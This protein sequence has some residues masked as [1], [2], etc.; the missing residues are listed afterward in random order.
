MQKFKIVP[1]GTLKGNCLSFEYFYNELIAGNI[2]EESGIITA[3]MINYQRTN[4]YVRGWGGYT[5]IKKNQAFVIS[6]KDLI[7]I[8]K[9]FIVDIVFKEKE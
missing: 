4:L 8:S 5:S 3:V 7:H 9:N 1:T 2:K 6:I